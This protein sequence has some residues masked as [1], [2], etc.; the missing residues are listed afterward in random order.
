MA[1]TRNLF[2][3]A[4]FGASCAASFFLGDDAYRKLIKANRDNTDASFPEPDAKE[5]ATEILLE[6]IDFTN[7][8]AVLYAPETNVSNAHD[9]VIVLPDAR[10]A[11]SQ[12]TKLVAHYRR[13]GMHVL[14]VHPRGCGKSGGRYIGYGYDDRLDVISW[15][16]RLLRQDAKAKIALHGL[17]SGAA[18]AILAGAEH[19]PASVYAIV[20]DSCFTTLSAYLERQ[21]TFVYPGML[22]AKIR[23]LLLRMVTLVRAGYDLREVAPEKSVEKMNVPTLFLH[24]DADKQ[25]PVDMCRAL[26]HRAGCTRQIGVFLGAGHLEGMNLSEERYFGQTDAFLSRQH[27]DRM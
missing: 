24:G 23:L 3:T 5:G 1:K 2:F 10:H 26:Y 16:H 6:A 19:L 14:V 27:P 17:G 25:M 11:G 18:S 8:Y 20:S 7:L 22:P 21:L 12:V 4:L 15:I 13:A 9:Y